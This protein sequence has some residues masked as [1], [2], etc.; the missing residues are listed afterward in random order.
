MADFKIEPDGHGFML[1]GELDMSCS[2]DFKLA[3]GRLIS[4]GG[5]VSIDMRHLRFMDSSGIAVILAGAREAPEDSCI[6]LHGVHDT[7]ER[8]VGVTGIEA[9]P[10]LHVISCTVGL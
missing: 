8:V 2:E 9:V 10:N 7:V 6:T 1:S 5:P 3:L 4:H